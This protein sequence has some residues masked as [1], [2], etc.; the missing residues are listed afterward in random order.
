ML[1]SSTLKCRLETLPRLSVFFLA[2]AVHCLYGR[3]REKWSE[4]ERENEKER[5]SKREREREKER[6]TE[7]QTID[8]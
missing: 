1:F 6:K 5:E 2:H 7:N 4:E 8:E 3:A